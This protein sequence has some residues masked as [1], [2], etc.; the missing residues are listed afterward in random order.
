MATWKQMPL[1]LSKTVPQIIGWFTRDKRVEESAE[2]YQP[3][4][5]NQL[6]KQR[7]IVSKESG[8]IYQVLNRSEWSSTFL[9]LLSYLHGLLELLTLCAPVFCAIDSHRNTFPWNNFKVPTGYNQYLFSDSR[10]NSHGNCCDHPPAAYFHYIDLHVS[11]LFE[12]VHTGQNITNRLRILSFHGFQRT[13]EECVCVFM[14][15]WIHDPRE[16][17][18]LASM[19]WSHGSRA[20][21]DCMFEVKGLFSRCIT[22]PTLLRSSVFFHFLAT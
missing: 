18:R 11:C 12:I 10:V 17:A 6:C 22:H 21:W 5:A 7:R 15:R 9:E 3:F 16:G 13:F 20:F 14:T 4:I 2:H 1:R 8:Y 19:Q